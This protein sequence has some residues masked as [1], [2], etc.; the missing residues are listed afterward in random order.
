MNVAE[1]LDTVEQTLLSRQL[2]SL[3]HF[4]LC[5]SWGGR[6]YSEMVPE[7]AYSI[8][9]IKD[10]GSQLWQALSKALG[11]RV[12]KKNLFLVL[13][14][15]LLSQTIQR[16]VGSTVQGVEKGEVQQGVGGRVWGVGEEEDGDCHPNE[17]LNC[18]FNDSQVK[19]SFT[20][21]HPH[22]SSGPHPTPG[23]PIPPQLNTDDGVSWARPDEECDPT[24]PPSSQLTLLP[25]Q[26]SLTKPATPHL[27]PGA[28][29]PP[30]LNSEQES[31]RA[32]GKNVG[33]QNIKPPVTM[34]HWLP[35]W[36]GLNPLV[37]GTFCPLPPAS[38][39]LQ[40][41]SVTLELVVNNRPTSNA[42]Q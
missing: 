37:N 4:I 6:G 28:P 19:N 24:L 8:A 21:P 40:P 22:Y 25:R 26:N 3:E 14:Q 41:S 18:Q 34:L 36:R 29:I 7:C 2:T 27:T 32:E 31:Q 23:A 17:P 15:Y 42:Y 20:T 9:H 33:S 10:I 1:V 35:E 38:C 11:Q 13:K 30:K 39:L 12:T 5:Q 16:G